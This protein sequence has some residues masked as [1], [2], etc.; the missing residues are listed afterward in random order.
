[1]RNVTKYI[2]IQNKKWHKEKNEIAATAYIFSINFII[3]IIIYTKKMCDNLPR[4]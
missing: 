4:K 3:I 1:M 2:N